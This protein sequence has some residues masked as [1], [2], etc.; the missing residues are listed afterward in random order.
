[1][2]E[3]VGVLA[4]DRAVDGDDEPPLVSSSWMRKRAA[5]RAP[6]PA[7]AAWMTM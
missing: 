5:A 3:V 1:M 2:D 6:R 4:R 7:M